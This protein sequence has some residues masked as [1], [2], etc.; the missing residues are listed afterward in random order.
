MAGAG[1]TGDWEIDLVAGTVTGL[2]PVGGDLAAAGGPVGLEAFLATIDPADREHVHHQIGV[3][4]SAGTLAVEYRAVEPVG[5][6]R[7]IRA[8]G[9]LVQ[10]EEGRGARVAG[11][12]TDVTEE[13][14]GR[15][16]VAEARHRILAVVSTA[17]TA[18]F[19]WDPAH[20][21][22]EW[23]ERGF[24]LL[25]LGGHPEPGTLEHLLGV[26]FE[27]DR[28][29]VRERFRA[30]PAPIE[31]EFRVRSAE[32]RIRWIHARGRLFRTGERGG[33]VAGVCTDVTDRRRAEEAAARL[34]AIVE[35][36]ADAIVGKDLD[37]FVTSWNQGAER[38]FGYTAEEMIGRHITTLLPP[39][40]RH[41]EDLILDRVRA[42]ER[43]DHFET[44][45]LRKDGRRV[46]ISLAVSPI[47]D[48]A[49][50]LIGVSKVARDLTERRQANA[51]Q[52]HLAA[53]VESS[54]DAI[55]SKDLDGFVTSW[56]EGAERLFGYTA[57]EMIG[58]HIRTLIP[59]DRW[60]EEDHILASVR[61]GRRVDHF[62]TERLRKDGR[63]VPI[64]LAVSP[65]RDGSGRIIGA[66]KVA[67][68]ITER[69]LAQER[70]ARHNEELNRA[71][72]AARAELE[73]SNQALRLAER[74]AALGTLAAGL[75]HDIG[76]LLV[77]LRI[78]V[79]A[80]KRRHA[81]DAAT[82]EHIAAVEHCADYF[83]SLVRGLRMV[84]RG[85]SGGTTD[86]AEWRSDAVPLLRNLV[87]RSVRLSAVFDEGLPPVRIAAGSLTQV[88][89]NL[90]KNGADAIGPNRGDGRVEL[91]ARRAEGGVRIEVADNGPG[92]TPEVRS[93]CLEP[94]FTT[95]T[96]GRETGTG[97]GLAVVHQVV[98]D[99]QGRLEIASEPGAGTTVSLWLPSAVGTSGPGRAQIRL[100][101]ERLRAIVTSMLR[102]A[103][104]EPEASPDVLDPGAPLWVVDAVDASELARRPE[105]LPVLLVGGNGSTSGLARAGL[106]RLPARPSA[107]E[108]LA[109]IREATGAPANGA[110]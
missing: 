95:R 55:A 97:L 70:L 8:A 2:P 26:V 50:R 37:G 23:D 29:R 87:G 109:A 41:E 57:E 72:E 102:T 110:A 94:Y 15:G 19:R 101:D 28:E 79:D 3:V 46:P 4:A 63:R 24:R 10:G 31:V 83:G 1:R 65:I 76:N 44:E 32:G 20:D 16:S 64:S 68:D 69:K 60:S 22:L 89:L 53:I 13:M 107:A 48:G 103:R 43:V 100:G 78:H 66:S 56:N 71:V 52:A 85:E 7:W 12:W 42:G 86:L 88:L 36:S 77:P 49:G 39:E 92:M 5:A 105:G 108:M 104:F 21:V 91:R 98:T 81:G 33:V 99:A 47:R 6:V 84:G 58:R 90:V 59:A 45:R 14:L 82:L 62:E 54:Q 11:T 27:A 17:S 93:R 38:L 74:M 75:G 30:A 96:R 34:S 73:R 25:G 106:R 40:R 18:V 80:I 61:S 9:E 35:S 51:L 67:R